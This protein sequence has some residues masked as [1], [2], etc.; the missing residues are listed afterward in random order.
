MHAIQY[1]NICFGGYS[2]LYIYRVFSSY[3]ILSIY[4]ISLEYSIPH[5][6]HMKLNTNHI[7]VAPTDSKWM[8][9][10]RGVVCHFASFYS[11][12][13]I[14][15][16]YPRERIW[17]VGSDFTGMYNILYIYI[18]THIKLYIYI[19]ILYIYIYMYVV[20]SIISYDMISYHIPHAMYPW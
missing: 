16:F 6:K 5:T 11:Y 2:T 8:I 3:P 13:A 9:D 17:G 20:Y 10:T 12:L 15:P 14:Y 18:Y 19:I 1:S 7:R 4:T